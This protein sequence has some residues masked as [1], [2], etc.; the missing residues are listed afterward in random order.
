MLISFNW[1]KHY[2]SLP[3]SV[4]AEEVAEK[5]KLATVEVEKIEHLG[6]NLE[7]VVVGKIL[8]VE[9][10]PNA[11]RLKVC[12]VDVGNETL[13]I[14]CG[15]SNV[16][17]GMKVVVAKLGARVLW[18]GQGEPV[19]ME[20]T[21]IR[22]VE[23]SGMICAA[24]E[25]G[26]GEQFPKK[27]DKEIVDLTHLPAKPGTALAVALGLSDTVFEIDNKSL[28]N[29]PDLLGH[30][31][32]AREVAVLYNREVKPYDA[33]VFKEDK[34]I[35]IEA[36]LGVKAEVSRYM[37]VALTG[38]AVKESPAWLKAKLAA[39]GVNSVNN[40]VD[41]TNYVML[42]LGQPLHAFDARAVMRDGASVAIQ[43]R[44]A[45]DGEELVTLDNEQKK[46]D[47]GVLV[48]A[49]ERQPIALAGIMGGKD[50][51]VHNETQAIV[52]EAAC[53]EAA[54]IRR[55]SARTHTRTDA[56]MRFEKSLDPNLC[57]LALK[58]AVQLI[59][60]MCPQAKVASPTID[61]Y[62]ASI[63]P[64]TLTLPTSFFADKIGAVVDMKA[65]LKIL[66]RLGFVVEE[67]KTSWKI[68]VPTWRAT[69]DIEIAEDVVEEVL[70]FIG[71]KNIPPTLPQFALAAL[72]KNR[73]L[74]LKR[75]MLDVAVQEF[76]YSE[77]Y[78]YSFISAESLQRFGENTDNYIELSNP[79]AKDRP[80][81]RRSLS[82]SLLESV[83]KNNDRFSTL[84]LVEMG[85]VYLKE[86]AGARSGTQSDEL[87]P[88]QPT[89]FSLIYT[90]K[91]EQNPWFAVRCLLERMARQAG[92][93]FS[94]QT[95]VEK[96]S[97][98]HPGRVA[99]IVVQEQMVGTVYE[100][101][102]AILAASKIEQKV[103]ILELN[104]TLL[105]STVGDVPSAYHPLSLFPQ[106][107]RDIA[108]TVKD[109]VSHAE[110]VETIS[111]DPL[112]QKVELF[113]VYTGEHIRTGYKSMAY[114]LT[115][116]VPDRTLTT[117]EVEQAYTKII[118]R[119]TERFAIEVRV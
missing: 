65:A 118:D 44:L 26:V 32:L 58:K 92:F 10:H 2:V 22:G 100:V 6:K 38:I 71:F 98:H 8:K 88:S 56:S 86:E 90:Q 108:F 34:Q 39:V 13:S 35:K 17:N 51:G 50:S 27:D 42:D 31:G 94:L 36:K 40:V 28:S 102:P 29:R 33:P 11:D 119:L 85:Q 41:V 62:R 9:P 53:F 96:K 110:L 60:E 23:S 49:D 59:I 115:F 48:I 106:V 61:L 69:K 54:A 3:D 79:L 5:L 74:D 20:K 43:V 114:R 75:I 76:G 103:A 19:V 87:L 84:R 81:L 18:H 93:S 67:K 91:K 47:P 68:T 63:K 70:R 113:D 55:A 7:N 66:E 116:A 80:F 12:S 52:L 101:H 73:L 112:L 57:E 45:A 78:N 104:L 64:K 25:V 16:A 1:L 82:V 72:P 4:S 97:L 37:A 109:S 117:A 99:A 83:I 14:V 24:D 89:L 107:E 21:A 46:L 77:V 30:Y 15:G 111:G 105:S 95:V